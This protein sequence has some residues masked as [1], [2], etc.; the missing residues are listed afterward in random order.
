MRIAVV[1][2][3]HAN[4]EAFRQ[5]PADIDQSGVDSVVCLGDNI[6]YGPE[7]EEVVH[8]IRK[9]NIPSVMRNHELL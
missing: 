4:L 8:L 1:S 3:I 2:D 6:G 5:V 7:P 9:R